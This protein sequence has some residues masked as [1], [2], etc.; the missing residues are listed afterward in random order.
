MALGLEYPDSTLTGA[1]FLPTNLHDSPVDLIG[2]G[3]TEVNKSVKRYTFVCSG[4]CNG[5]S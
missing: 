4:F 5:N 2:V 1:N 3:R